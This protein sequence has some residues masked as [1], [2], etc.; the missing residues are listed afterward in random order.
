LVAQR[1]E[2]RVSVVYVAISE[3]ESG[4][5]I[6][7][8]LL[9]RLKGVPRSRVYRLL[10][11]GE[12]RVNKGRV[13]PTYRLRPGDNVRI[14]PV[15]M[16][17][18]GHRPVVSSLARDALLGQILFE[19]DR[20]L[21]VDKPSGMAVHGGSGLSFGVIEAL[22]AAR[23]DCPY[24]ELVHRLDRET[25]GCLLIAK[26]RSYL[27]SL[28]ELLREG[29]LDKRY[30]ALVAGDWQRGRI[31]LEDRLSTRTRRDG[32]RH[33]SLDA[34]GKKAASRFGLVQSFRTASL[35]EVQLL[36]GRTHQIRVQAT[37]AGHPLAGDEKYGDRQFNE[38]MR[39]LGLKRMFL[40]AH[41]LGFDDP[42]T[43]EHRAFSA[44]LPED[45]RRV[46][47]RL[48]TGRA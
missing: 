48:E 35:L 31:L 33:V 40:H 16:A 11:R 6:D 19:D 22:R 10:R 2:N 42:V 9:A 27:R 1:S 20:L 26:R 34:G 18:S 23:P 3:A 29:R 4:Q 5:R 32:E 24:L 38:R 13:G 25:S 39:G 41:A 12:V 45:L 17:D 47:D 8:F 7:N 37:A 30:L 14:P 36:T 43:G 28:H 46:I 21:V 15:R 44:P